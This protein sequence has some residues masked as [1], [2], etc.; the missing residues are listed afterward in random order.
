VSSDIVVEFEQESVSLTLLNCSVAASAVK[1]IAAKLSLRSTMEFFYD[2][3]L[4]LSIY[5]TFCLRK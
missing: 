3:E 2:S 1:Q 4:E 5:S